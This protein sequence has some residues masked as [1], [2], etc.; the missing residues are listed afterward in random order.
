MY[1]DRIARASYKT[2]THS[3]HSTQLLSL[4]ISDSD[5]SFYNISTTTQ[6][7]RTQQR[8]TFR[9]CRPLRQRSSVPGHLD[10]LFLSRKSIHTNITTQIRFQPC[11]RTAYSPQIY[12]QLH[13][14]FLHLL[15]ISWKFWIKNWKK[16]SHFFSKR[17]ERER[18]EIFKIFNWHC[19][20][21]S[22]N[23]PDFFRNHQI[24]WKRIWLCEVRNFLKNFEISYYSHIKY[25][26]S[27]W[28]NI[29]KRERE[30][31]RER[32]ESTNHFVD[33]TDNGKYLEK[34][35]MLRPSCGACNFGKS[36]EGIN[37]EGYH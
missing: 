5:V 18:V 8:A 22:A 3:K 11:T 26:D 13:Q 20:N 21:F 4:P 33:I 28:I 12:Q 16:P 25:C 32:E 34:D 6:S 1:Q 15:L 24:N 2:E 14:S 19:R 31:K 30:M 9:K 29:H 7:Q 35:E 23:T 27:Y 17:R 36:Y 10:Q 37:N